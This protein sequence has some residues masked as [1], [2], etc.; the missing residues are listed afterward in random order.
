MCGINGIIR[1]D[2]A[3]PPQAELWV[4][5]MNK[6]IAHRGPDDEGLWISPGR[7]ACL[8]HRRLS[9]LDLSSAGHQP[10]VD[11]AGNAITYNGEI[12]NYWNIRNSMGGDRRF[13]STTDTEVLLNL[14]SKQDKAALEPLNGMFAFAHWNEQQ[15]SAWLVRDPAGKKPLYYTIQDGYLSFSSEI[16]A[17]L[18]LPFIRAVPD[19]EALYHFLTY[20]QVPGS[21]TLFKGIHKLEPGHHL[22][23][24]SGQLKI[25]RW[26]EIE[27]VQPVVSREQDASDKIIQTLKEAVGLRMVSD[28]PVGAFLSGGV[29]SSAIVA[30]MQQYGRTTTH[31]YS[32]GFNGLNGFD[33]LDEAEKT[34]KSFGTVH[35]VRD[36]DSGDFVACLPSIIDSFDEPLADATA[37]PI[38]FL[39]DMARQDGVPVILTGD[40]ADELFAGYQSWMRYKRLQPFF[41]LYSALPMPVR[42]LIASPLAGVWSEGSPASEML[43]RGLKRQSLFWGGARGF[44]ESVKSKLLESEY[45][46]RMKGVNSYSVIESLNAQFDRLVA[47]NP[48]LDFTDRMCY[49]GFKFQVPSKYLFRM[50]RL[51]MAHGVEVRS[52]FLDKEM[53]QLAFSLPGNLKQ[54]NGIPKYILKRSL[55]SILPKSTLYRKKTGFCVPL[56]EWAGEMILEHTATHYREFCRNTGLFDEKGITDLLTSF[57]KNDRDHTNELWTVYFL[58]AWF[59]KWMSA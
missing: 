10:M 59:K 4:A 17:L 14:I 28:V 30:L 55:E 52:P 19:E 53:V 33:E 36:V 43:Q 6:R 50:D 48:H 27:P 47:I 18:T 58:M 42:A 49:I 41:S 23:A 37:I 12:Y 1:F 57:R 2:S 31:T 44:K 13:R 29:D 20:N 25:E 5:A 56:K 45:R 21:L 9:I 26:W 34:A 39:S 16:K 54:K 40:G 24:Q 8:G 51:G 38:H 22:C 11:E 35:R 32:I 7:K 15:E 46:N 3:L